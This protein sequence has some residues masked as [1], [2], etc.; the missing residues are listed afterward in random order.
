MLPQLR[1]RGLNQRSP[2]CLS[3]ITTGYVHL[4][5]VGAAAVVM[6]HESV[7]D[8]VAAFRHH[9][10]PTGNIYYDRLKC[11]CTPLPGVNVC[12]QNL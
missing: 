10:W 1:V 9:S 8:E 5:A 3:A 2:L 11:A 6:V 7:D 4:Q 12:D